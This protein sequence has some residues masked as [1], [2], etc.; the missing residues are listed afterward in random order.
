MIQN[1]KHGDGVIR[2]C[3]KWIAENYEQAD[4][5]AEVVRQSGLPKRTFDRR[6]KAATGY[7]P[8]AYIQA[9]RIEEA[10]QI[11]ETSRRRVE[12]IGRQVGYED[13]ASFRRLFR[14]LA[15]H[16]S[17][18]L[19]TQAAAAGD[20]PRSGRRPRNTHSRAEARSR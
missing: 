10:K 12:A 20:H 9:L 7:S 6:F 8:L 13:A 16:E 1:V 4:I 2:N 3:Q 5:V 19:P 18:R 14:R 15:G 11:L 17:W